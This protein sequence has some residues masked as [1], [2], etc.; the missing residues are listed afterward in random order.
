MQDFYHEGARLAVSRQGRSEVPV[1]MLHSS[2]ASHRQWGG[3]ADDLAQDFSVVAPDFYGHGG[4]VRAPLSGKLGFLD[5]V[6]LV[7][8]VI[9]D[10]PGP[11]HVIGHSYGGA[12]AIQL[13]CQ[14]PALLRSITV[15]EPVAFFLLPTSGKPEGYAEIKALSEQF[16][17]FVAAGDL[18]SCGA[19]FIDYWMGRDAWSAL[20]EK[21]RSSIL[22]ALPAVADI[23]DLLG[24]EARSTSGAHDALRR[25]E[26]PSL[27]MR[28]QH[29]TQ[30]A[31][32][33]ICI[34]RR[35][36]PQCDYAQ[37]AD[38]GHMAPLTHATQVNARITSFLRN[39]PA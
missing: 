8:A 24:E 4:S 1:V 20:P 9:E 31:K 25:F 17:A 13:A 19:L 10:L 6:A 2:A 18:E 37:I 38:A 7:R 14:A 36:W 29:T 21:N 5:D 32:A 34:L 30:A 39:L 22:A 15:F 23:W 11:A 33:V 35:I 3:L 28:A 16:K 27:V 26:R 12:V